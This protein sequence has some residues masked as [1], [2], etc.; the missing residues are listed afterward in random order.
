MKRLASHY[1]YFSPEHYYKQHYIELT[2][3]NRL[4]GIH[5]LTHETANTEFYNGVLIVKE[6]G[7]DEPVEVYHLPTPDLSAAELCASNG[8]GD[9]HIKRL[10]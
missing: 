6:A 3:D 8:G 5:P 1:I 9:S 10:C 2:A 4:V 7:E